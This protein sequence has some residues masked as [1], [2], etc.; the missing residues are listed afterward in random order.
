MKKKTLHGLRLLLTLL[1]VAGGLYAPA[2]QLETTLQQNADKYQPERAYLHYDKSTYYPGETVWFKAYLMEDIYPVTG[3]KSFYLDWIGENGQLLSHTVWP[4]VEG[5]ASGQFTVPANYTGQAIQARGY[6][7]W[8]LNFDTAFLYS[9]NIRILGRTPSTGSAAAQ[10][11]KTPSS[12]NNNS[13]TVRKAPVASLQF[14]PEGGELVSGVPNR[15]AFKANDQY[16]KPV[17]VKGEIRDGKGALVQSFSTVHE[18]LGTVNIIPDESQSY[19][20]RWKDAKGAEQVTPLPAVKRSG[21]AMMVSRNGNRRVV[22]MNSSPSS[23]ETMRQLNLVG[24]MNGRLAFRTAVSIAPGGSGQKIIP[25]ENLP[26]GVLTL[27]VFDSQWKPVAERITYINN[28]D[29]SFRTEMQVEHWG[30][31]KRGKNELRITIPDSLDANLSIS[32]TDAEIGGDSSENIF[33]GLLLAGYLKGQ[34]YNSAYYFSNNSDSVQQ[35][36]DFV[37]LTHGWRRFDWDNLVKGKLPAFTQPKDTTY[38]AVSGQLYGITRGQVSPSDNIVLIMKE[39]DTSSR[40]A[41]MP[42]DQKGY[43]SDPELMFFDTLRV[44]YQLKTKTLRGADVRFMTDRLPAP[45][46]G[47]SGKLVDVFPPWVDTSG[48]YRHALLAGEA[49]RLEGSRNSRMMENITVTAKTKTPLQQLDEKYSRGLFSGG[50]SYNFDL[51]NNPASGYINI[52]DYLQGRV[53]GLQINGESMQWRGGTPQLFLDE[54]PTDVDM[55]GNV[56]VS[57]I[58]FIKVF[59]PPFMGASGGGSGGAIAIYTRRGSDVP[60]R[61]G[62]G[63]QR[64]TIAGYTAVRQFYSPNYSIIDRRNEEKD[65]RTT[66]Y[67]N[68]VIL[69]SKKN[70]SVVVRFYNNDTS[71]AFRVVIEGMTREGLLTRHVEM[72]E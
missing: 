6:T 40:V 56:P 10:N 38:L 36:L 28:N 30:L 27:T 62:T 41:F 32:V 16:G 22:V 14:F 9:K 44:Y 26:T 39:N 42:I 70:R 4:I 35:H 72:M 18:G 23:P 21:I 31:S 57:D 64:H 15:I 20:A 49:L 58:A 11:T 67:W 13:N 59:R 48:Q 19:T 37:M 68:P 1:L 34:V 5:A 61:P 29:Y 25:T 3:S 55:I 52:L 65:V 33:S 47:P 8:M 50:D 69:T 7:K 17:Q 45:N 12:P 63:M 60:D 53:P 2:Q 51:V 43:F 71:K 66:L 46:Y 54:I 24:T